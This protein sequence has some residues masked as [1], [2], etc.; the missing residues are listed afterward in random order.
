MPVECI[1]ILQRTPFNEGSAFQ[2]H[3]YE[4]IDGKVHYAVD[5]LDESNACIT[6]LEFAERDAA[7]LVR[8][9][10]D[11]TILSPLNGGNRAA[12]LEVPN[13]GHRIA[14]RIINMCEPNDDDNLIEP[15]DGY[16][17]RQGWTLVFCGWQWDVPKG[18]GRLGLNAPMVPKPR[19]GRMQIRFQPHTQVADLRPDLSAANLSGRWRRAAGVT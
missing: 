5:P 17:F 7:G 19:N 9:S 13:R 3:V 6:D 4:R 11:V 10:G 15:G 1:E 18:D 16:L 12:L 2:G 14:N 8:F